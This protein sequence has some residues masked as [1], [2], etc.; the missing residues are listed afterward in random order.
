MSKKELHKINR[1]LEKNK[2]YLSYLVDYAR[3]IASIEYL[4]PLA[5]SL[6][7]R[8]LSYDLSKEHCS[9]LTT[10]LRDIYSLDTDAAE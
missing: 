9:I 4:L 5:S 10:T 8:T 6:A 2:K 3:V 7:K 1:D